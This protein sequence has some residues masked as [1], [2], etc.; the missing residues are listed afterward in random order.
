M[1]F[2][3]YNT[4]LKK[5][6]QEHLLQFWNELNKEQQSALCN[7][8][9]SIN[10]KLLQQ[11]SEKALNSHTDPL[12]EQL[13][14]ANLVSLEQRKKSDPAMVELG[15]TLLKEGKVGVFLVAGG[16]GSR[17]G[18]EGPKGCYKI[19]P[20][21]RKSLFQL[22][23]EKI[24][25]LAQK[26][27]TTIPWYIMTSVTN[28]NET[29][30][31]FEQNGYWGLNP[32]DVM[33]FKQEML[34]AID[35]KGKLILE[36]KHSVFMS[37]NG[38]GGSL[39]AL[40]DSGA[41]ADMEKRGIKYLYYFQVDNVL[42][43]IGDPAFLGY[44]VHHQSQMSSKVVRKAFPEE[45]MGIICN[46][47]GKTGVIEYSDLRPEEMY[48]TNKD[49][50]LKY[51]AGSIAIHIL[52]TAF[53]EKE[54]KKGFRLPYHI[55]EKSIP[56]MDQNGDKIIPDDKNGFKFETFVFDALSHCS[57]T[58]SV[59]ID[60]AEEFSALKNKNGVDSEETA[61]RDMSRQ[62]MNWLK[63]C[64]VD[65]PDI[66]EGASIPAL[67]ISPLFALSALDLKEKIES[68]PKIKPNLYIG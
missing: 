52:D 40:W 13:E 30:T 7:Q 46:N 49:G 26:Y 62:F 67:E 16:Q 47:N 48:E 14:E 39:K 43:Q 9:D 19:S 64:G 37:P 25:A 15:N 63:T 44:H 45:K 20:V 23:A 42:I 35:K 32:N 11:L 36:E 59:E 65:V 57:K 17:L 55:A 54:N 3:K 22:H 41:W 12:Y 6:K 34:P 1:P 51:W 68:I 38:H 53:I 4:L 27:N 5:Y 56:Y 21:K 58:I 8:I 24:S 50:S 66:E 33:F 61:I 28:H 10:F 18:F 31:F 2:E 60:R 29:V